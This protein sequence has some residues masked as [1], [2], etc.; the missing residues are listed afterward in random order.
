MTNQ[1]EISPYAYIAVTAVV[2]LIGSFLAYLASKKNS[3]NTA[4]QANT[5]ANHLLLELIEPLKE[6]ISELEKAGEKAKK[7]ILEL[8]DKWTNDRCDKK[9]CKERIP[10]KVA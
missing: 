2:T 8:K 4:Q 3:K 1:S 6:R 9:N 7:E 10:P 5:E